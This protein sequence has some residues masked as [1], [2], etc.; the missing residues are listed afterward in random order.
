MSATIRVNDLIKVLCN[1]WKPCD[2]IAVE[3]LELII[4]DNGGRK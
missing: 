3:D 4:A 2:V 1:D